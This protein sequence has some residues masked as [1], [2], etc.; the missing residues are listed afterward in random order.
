MDAL[1]VYGNDFKLVMCGSDVGV[2]AAGRGFTGTICGESV[3]TRLAP[4]FWKVPLRL[5]KD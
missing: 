2:M 4:S 3:G 1:D 5:L